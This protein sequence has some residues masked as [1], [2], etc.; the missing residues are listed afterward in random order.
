MRN[1]LIILSVIILISFS[2]C[3]QTPTAGG[4]FK[5]NTTGEPQITRSV[6][7]VAGSNTTIIQDTV[8][9][10]MTISSSLG[11]TESDPIAMANISSNFA[12]WSLDTGD[13]ISESFDPCNPANQASSWN[14]SYGSCVSIV[15]SD[16]QTLAEVLTQGNTANMNISMNGYH[17]IGY[18]NTDFPNTSL[19]DYLLTATYGTNFP[20]NNITA[21]NISLWSEQLKFPMGYVAFSNTTQFENLS[22]WTSYES[23]MLRLHLD[24]NIS[25]TVNLT[26]YPCSLYSDW[27]DIYLYEDNIQTQYLVGGSSDNLGWPCPDSPRKQSFTVNITDTRNI[28]V[29]ST[30]EPGFIK[31]ISIAYRFLNKSEVTSTYNESYNSHILNFSNPHNTPDNLKVNKTGDNITG[32]LILS[33]VPSSVLSFDGVND[34]VNAGNANSLNITNTITLEAWVK[35]SGWGS[36]QY[37]RIVDKKGEG[38]PGYAFMLYSGNSGL[39][40]NCDAQG[41]SSNSNVITLNQWQHIAVTANGTHIRFYVNGISAGTN[42]SSAL[43]NATALNL[44]IGDR[45]GSTGSRS[46]NGAIDEV[47]IY[48]RALTE[49]EI[50]NLYNGTYVNRSCL[51]LEINMNEEQGTTTYDSSGYDNHGTLANSVAWDYSYLPLKYNNDIYLNKTGTIMRK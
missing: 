17:I 47:R 8:N 41:F 45:S 49:N 11:T 35:P 4:N 30:G 24:Y 36:S 38:S 14:G 42:A 12:A 22:S 6:E 50:K 21:D 34:Y 48:N 43:P 32:N 7:L 23:D 13:N 51:V 20:N 15:S 25:G 9:K 31:N 29:K 3:L 10:T 16:D 27:I 1:E 19:A 37:P 40:L 28:G 2:G 5:I 33:S 26:F 18:G 39:V 44:W 46:F